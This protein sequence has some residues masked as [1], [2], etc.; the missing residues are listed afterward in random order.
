MSFWF[1]ASLLSG[2]ALAALYFSFARDYERRTC[3]FSDDALLL[4]SSSYFADPSLGSA[5]IELQD[6]FAN[7]ERMHAVVKAQFNKINTFQTTVDNL[8]VLDSDSKKIMNILVK[9]APHE[10]LEIIRIITSDISQM[11]SILHSK[12]TDEHTLEKW[13]NN[14]NFLLAKKIIE[15]Y[16]SLKQHS[17]AEFNSLYKKTTL[18][19][20]NY[21][22][23]LNIAETRISQIY[24]RNNY[25]QISCAINKINAH[26]LAANKDLAALRQK[27][28]S[29]TQDRLLVI[30]NTFAIVSGRDANGALSQLE[31]H[32]QEYE[33]ALKETIELYS[34]NK[35]LYTK[36]RIYHTA[37]GYILAAVASLVLSYII[38]RTYAGL[39]ER[40]IMGYIGDDSNY[41]DIPM[42][43][44]DINDCKRDN[45]L[46]RKNNQF[47]AYVPET[48]EIS[49]GSDEEKVDIGSQI[50]P[51]FTK[52]EDKL[53]QTITLEMGES[54]NYHVS[55]HKLSF[56]YCIKRKYMK[57]RFWNSFFIT[58]ITC[59]S[60]YHYSVPLINAYV[61]STV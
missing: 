36:A 29:I 6:A 8:N 31:L 35:S 57:G 30:D 61:Y 2:A 25:P 9:G 32:V 10:L 12:F 7:L 28:N 33:K 38:A 45:P 49:G 5:G 1:S 59:M 46:W 53:L 17:T 3:P 42:D 15:L 14:D 39:A 54:Y 60:I 55:Q 13:T 47:Y 23:A 18:E 37:L 43:N 16:S 50:Q 44:L 19:L 11:R 51:L 58:F 26:K 27:N 20:E 24:Q 41:K 56:D 21:I 4:L 52:M 22:Q 40:T 48:R 34:N